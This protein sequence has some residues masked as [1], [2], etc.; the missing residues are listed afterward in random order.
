MRTVVMVATLIWSSAVAANETT[1]QALRIFGMMGTWSADCASAYTL[2]YTFADDKL[3]TWGIHDPWAKSR[4]D[5]AGDTL[6]TLAGRKPQRRVPTEVV[7]VKAVRTGDDKLQ[8]TAWPA[9]REPVHLL[10]EKVDLK[11]QSPAGLWEKCPAPQA[12]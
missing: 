10:L 1:E 11:V 9:G 4:V 8:I 7:T 2:R 3:T 5:I 12:L 6:A